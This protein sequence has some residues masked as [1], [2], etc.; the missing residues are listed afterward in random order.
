M[1]VRELSRVRLLNGYWVVEILS[2][3][4]GRWIVQGEWHTQAEAERDRRNWL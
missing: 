2:A 4:T 1:N 3:A